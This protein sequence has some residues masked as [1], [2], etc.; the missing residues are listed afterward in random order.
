[1]YKSNMQRDLDVPDVLIYVLQNLYFSR[2]L[3]LLYNC[4]VEKSKYND[5]YN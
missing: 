2:D 3:N 1:M 5:N 4:I